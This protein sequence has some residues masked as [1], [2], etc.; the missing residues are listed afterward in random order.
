MLQY[1]T[2]N[3]ATMIVALIVAAIVGFLSAF[4]PAYRAS[5]LNIA[6]GLRHL[7]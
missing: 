2:V 3:G 7:G 4:F 6:E 1:I 5:K